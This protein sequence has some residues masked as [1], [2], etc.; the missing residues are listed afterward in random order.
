MQRGR[1]NSQIQ[2]G[3]GLAVCASALTA[4]T[5]VQLLPVGPFRASDGRP[6]DAKAWQL[7]ADIAAKIIAKARARTNPIPIDY[8][9]QTLLAR[10]NGQ[11]AP[12]AGWYRTME[13]R[14]G[15]GLFATDV[16]WTDRAKRMIEAKEYLY[17]SPVFA[18][19]KRT[20][21][22]LE[23]LHGGITNTPALD[24]MSDLASRAAA[25]FGIDNPVASLRTVNADS[26]IK[27]LRKA[28]ARHMRHLDGSEPTTGPAGERSQKLM[29]EEMQKA[30]DELTG[31]T[32]PQETM[33]MKKLLELFGLSETA[34]EAEAVAA[35]SALIAKQKEGETALAAAKAQTPD[36]AQFVPVETVTK[37]QSDVAALTA[38]L[39]QNEIDSLVKAALSDGRV[40]PAMEAWAREL[41]KKDVAQLRA[42]INAAQPIAAL[43]GTQSGGKS[44][45]KKEGDLD[46]AQLAV[47]QQ[48]GVSAE[49]Y[50]KTVAA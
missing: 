6:L 25:A 31:T 44:P 17:F 15:Q 50:K 23:V 40:L 37:L 14:E 12:A 18:Y 34:T 7:N 24:G 32:S 11:P 49:D 35:A 21:E 28:I 29:M 20:G 45:E 46:E 30:L 1:L 36:P 4:G 47:C 26:A 42:F 39:N 10:E 48:L 19:D 3:I 8:E 27:W 41:G 38:T 13:W 33:Q 2:A 43:K 9:H 16:Q 5:E 22:V